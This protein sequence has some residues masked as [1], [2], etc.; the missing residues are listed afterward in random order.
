VGVG[1]V[2]QLRVIGVA[3]SYTYIHIHILIYN[4]YIY[5]Y[6]Y[7]YPYTSIYSTY[8]ELVGVGPVLEL[9]I[10]GVAISRVE[11]ERIPQGDVVVEQSDD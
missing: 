1:P 3:V 2:L 9:L 8:L 10:N 5:I 7:I 4:I 6:T 11:I